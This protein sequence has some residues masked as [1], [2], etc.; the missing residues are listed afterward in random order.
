MNDGPKQ[1]V[2][3]TAFASICGE[4]AQQH[5]DDWPAVERHIKQCVE[6]L[7]TDRR[8]RLASEVARGLRYCAP[9]GDA[10]TQ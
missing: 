10:P 6:A 3:L 7:P 9:N 5:G 8:Q 1:D 2:A 4:A